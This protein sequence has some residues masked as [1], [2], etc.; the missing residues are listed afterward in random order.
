MK[1]LGLAVLAIALLAPACAAP[2]AREDGGDVVDG[3][4]AVGN[5][6]D[7]TTWEPLVRAAGATPHPGGLVTVLGIRG[8]GLE[9]ERHDATSKE[10]YDDT[11]V[12]LKPDHTAIILAGSTHPFQ[13][14]GVS[15][16]PDVDGDGALDVG[17][18]RPGQYLAVGRGN[19]RLV[20]GLPAYDVVT[21]DGRD[22]RL[23]GVRDTN[24]DG[25]FDAE[26][27]ERSLG[28]N[29]GLTAVLF[30]HGDKG[31]PAVVGCQVLSAASMKT[32]IRAVGGAATK[33]HYVLVDA[34]PEESEP[35]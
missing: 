18:I 11:F 29:D 27:S 23:P 19:T 17:R 7:Y 34:P 26:E 25:V 24:H 2:S 21:F 12:V 30:H 16:V 8:R 6:T 20:G 3:D 22:G 35:R 13:A 32:L 15:G 4:D 10:A 14:R 9:G 31:A 1:S 33:F 5:E 28:R